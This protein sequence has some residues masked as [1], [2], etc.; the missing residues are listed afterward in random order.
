MFLPHA[1][2]K[3]HIAFRM[4]RCKPIYSILCVWLRK[5]KDEQKLCKYIHVRAKTKRTEQNWTKQRNAF[6]G[7]CWMLHVIHEVMTLLDRTRIRAS[8]FGLLSNSLLICAESIFYP[9]IIFFC[10]FVT[11]RKIY[12]KSSHRLMCVLNFK[13]CE[14]WISFVRCAIRGDIQNKEPNFDSIFFWFAH[15]FNGQEHSNLWNEMRSLFVFLLS[16]TA[17]LRIFTKTLLAQML[18]LFLVHISGLLLESNFPIY[19]LKLH[20]PVFQRSVNKFER[21]IKR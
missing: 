8:A 6:C 9:L 1:G 4:D 18:L 14:W 19:L 15:F 5:K 2:R 7:A 21:R 3:I 12:A 17:V 20:F 16:I 10:L 13:F 11:R